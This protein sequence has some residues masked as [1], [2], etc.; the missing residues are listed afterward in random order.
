MFE[1]TRYSDF[2]KGW[3]AVNAVEV[4]SYNGRRHEDGGDFDLIE[5]GGGNRD[6]ELA[7]F[8][9]LSVNNMLRL[10]DGLLPFMTR[11]PVAAPLDFSNYNR[12]IQHNVGKIVPVTDNSSASLDIAADDKLPDLNLH[13]NLLSAGSPKSN[14][15]LSAWNL[16]TELPADS[17]ELRRFP[18]IACNP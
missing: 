1:A 18:P 16:Q 8:S 5:R 15:Q 6:L 9:V 4:L 11:S 12:P 14:S 13:E 10:E 2:T 7:A 3:V 17:P